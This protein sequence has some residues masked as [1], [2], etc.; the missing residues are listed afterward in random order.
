IN[1]RAESVDL[2]ISKLIGVDANSIV[3]NVSNLLDNKLIYG[4]MVSDINPYGDGSAAE[5]I[6]EC[7]YKRLNNKY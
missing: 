3:E 4:K 2:G 7:I 6:I 1:R 5:K